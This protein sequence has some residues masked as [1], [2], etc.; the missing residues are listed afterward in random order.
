M[1][2]PGLSVVLQNEIAKT[3][4]KFGTKISN[5]RSVVLPWM[6]FPGLYN[7]IPT[8]AEYCVNNILVANL[9][10]RNWAKLINLNATPISATVLVS[11]A[12]GIIRCLTQK[13]LCIYFS[14]K[15]ELANFIFRFINLSP[16][17]HIYGLF[18]SKQDSKLA[19]DHLSP[20]RLIPHTSRMPG[21]TALS[22]AA[23]TAALATA[24]TLT[25]GTKRGPIIGIC[26]APLA[27][28]NTW[29]KKGHFSNCRQSYR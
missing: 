2:L 15:S 21:G 11:S 26:E 10:F 23:L 22:V 27:C 29:N 24:L 18:I 14:W 20:S 6:K 17:E 4:C 25:G 1:V 8:G 7:K 16:Q 3:D 12:I 9:E 28:F 13:I 19:D 5:I